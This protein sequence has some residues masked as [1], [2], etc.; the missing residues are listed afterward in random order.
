[1]PVKDQYADN[2]NA[3]NDASS[4]HGTADPY[5]HSEESAAVNVKGLDTNRKQHPEIG[6][7]GRGPILINDPEATSLN[8]AIYDNSNNEYFDADNYR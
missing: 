6:S 4:K 3:G 1:M 5:E 8:E 7:G 2:R